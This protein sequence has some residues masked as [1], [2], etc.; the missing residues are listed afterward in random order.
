MKFLYISL[1]IFLLPINM[2]AQWEWQNPK[3]Q[4]NDILDIQSVSENVGF[5]CGRHGTVV[6]TTSGG[7]EWSLLQFPRRMDLIKVHFVFETIGWV[8]GK[9]D[10]SVFLHKTTD[11]GI[12]WIEQINHDADLISIFFINES[13]GW[14]SLDSSLLRTHD[15]GNTWVQQTVLQVPISDIIFTDSTNGWVTGRDWVSGGS[16]VYYTS[17]GGE[18]WQFTSIDLRMIDKIEFFDSSVGWLM[19]RNEGPN[20]YSSQVFKS[21]DGGQTWQQQLVYEGWEYYHTFTDME[22]SSQ[23]FGWVISVCGLEF[24]TTNGGAEWEEMDLIPHLTQVSAIDNSTLWGAGEYGVHYSSLDGGVTWHRKNVGEIVRET[25]E[26]FVLNE[27]ICFTGG[28]EA[29]LKTINGGDTWDKIDVDIGLSDFT[30]NSIWFADSLNGWIGGSGG[31]FMTVDGGYNWINQVDNI[32]RINDIYFVNNTSGWFVSESKFYHTN[33]AGNSWFFQ[34]DQSQIAVLMTLQFTSPDSGWAGGFDGLI[35]TTDR[36]NTWSTINPNGL[37]INIS[38]IHFIDQQK[39][40][41]VGG[42]NESHILKTTD[43]GMSWAN[44]IHPNILFAQPKSVYFPDSE[45]GWVIG[46]AESYGFVFH[47]SNG[48]LIWEEVDFPTDHALYQVGFANQ[49]LG[50]ILGDGGRILNT[51]TGG[52]SFIEEIELKQPSNFYLTQNYPNPFNPV[53][54]IKFEIPGQARNDNTLVTLK[55]YDLLGREIATL[56]NEEKPAGEYEVEF[57]AVNLPSGIYFYRIQA[58]SYINTKKMV[59]L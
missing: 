51:T 27:N 38:A 18:T 43:G 45:N 34:T 7:S 52:I 23:M 8:A 24:R 2:F 48:G 53:T 4:G 46:S 22:F 5:A 15:G 13:L 17:D 44:Q 28:E 47:T 41:I 35:H 33:D 57:N 9:Q 26:L 12:N 10:S 25:T 36:G 59:L 16:K 1:L 42:Y 21:I 58:G 14:I 37:N 11:A 54:K 20:F 30:I 56:V 31:L 32:T 19:G 40:W 39:G 49:Q 6:K 29:L 50:W 3:P 55:V